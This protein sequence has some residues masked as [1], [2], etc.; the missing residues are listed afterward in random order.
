MNRPFQFP[1]KKNNQIIK[2]YW[3]YS[4]IPDALDKVVHELMVKWKVLQVIANIDQKYRGK[5]EG[6]WENLRSL[7]LL[8]V[9][10]KSS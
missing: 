8:F 6:T 9:W 2:N 7:H 10:G 1:Q 5:S 4:S 3:T